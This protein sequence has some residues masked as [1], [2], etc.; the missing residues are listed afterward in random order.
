MKYNRK[1]KPSAIDDKIVEDKVE[2]LKVKKFDP[3]LY[4]KD[5]FKQSHPSMSEEDLERVISC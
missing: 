1:V 3:F 2:K 4:Y 5:E